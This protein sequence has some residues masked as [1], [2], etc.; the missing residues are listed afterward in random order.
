MT[1][2][3]IYIKIF[4]F[5]KL[6]C[7]DVFGNNPTSGNQQPASLIVPCIFSKPPLLI[8]IF[9]KN[10]TFDQRF[11]NF[12]NTTFVGNTPLE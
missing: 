6:L 7:K 3:C 2:C 8:L 4:R 9:S 10:V 11:R 5:S 12:A 1:K